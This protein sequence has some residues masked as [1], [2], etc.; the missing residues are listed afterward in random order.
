MRNNIG[1]IDRI[2]RFTIAVTVGS[3]V[4][5]NAVDNGLVLL[6]MLVFSFWLMVT[7]LKGICPLYRLLGINTHKNLN[8]KARFYQFH[9]Q[10][11]SLL[12]EYFK[13]YQEKI[14]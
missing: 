7:C 14:S 2:V 5:S 4:F 12:K 9:Q 8:A 6:G 1:S 10:N 13:N 11:Q 3:L